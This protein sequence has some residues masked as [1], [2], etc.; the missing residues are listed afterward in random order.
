MITTILQYLTCLVLWFLLCHGHTL[1]TDMPDLLCTW[2]PSASHG[3]HRNK[4]TNPKLCMFT[5]QKWP[6]FLY[7]IYLF[8][9]ALP[10]VDRIGLKT[11][12]LKSLSVWM[13]QPGEQDAGGF[14]WFCIIPRGTQGHPGSQGQSHKMVTIINTRK[15]LTK[16]ICAT[17]ITFL[18]CIDQGLWERFA[19]VD[20]KIDRNYNPSL[21]S[22][23]GA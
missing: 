22:D 23:P 17:N 11:I 5:T 7:H 18:P 20:I 2:T 6:P 9:V 4:S 8:K 14:V 12:A 16:E 10:I 1:G 19:Y 21:S 3:H 15:W 13:F